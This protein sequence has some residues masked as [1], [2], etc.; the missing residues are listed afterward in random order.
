MTHTIMAVDDSQS[1]REIIKYALPGYS[2]ITAASGEAALDRI[3]TEK[4]DC[5]ITDLHMPGIDGIELIRRVRALPATA[6]IPILMLTTDSSDQKKI[7]GK[8]AG[9]TGWLV[10]P[11]TVAQLSAVIKKVL[12]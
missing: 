3:P 8:H 2:V 11:F 6:Y 5:L 10:K 1:I 9:A 4:I 7:E 12:G